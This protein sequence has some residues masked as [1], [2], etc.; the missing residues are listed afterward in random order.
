M[1]TAIA[2]SIP[3][4]VYTRPSNMLASAWLGM[5]WFGVSYAY[6]RPHIFKHQI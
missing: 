3:S 5:G 2:C 1:N 4:F 6:F